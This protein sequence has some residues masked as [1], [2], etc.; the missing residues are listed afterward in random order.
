MLPPVDSALMPSLAAPSSASWSKKWT[1]VH[2]G[3][4]FLPLLQPPA[5]S[6]LLAG[7]L[8]APAIE[9]NL[10]AG[11]A[12]HSHSHVLLRVNVGMYAFGLVWPK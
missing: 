11:V 8:G 3:V 6:A 2:L 4:V 10:C 5:A 9:P 12:C 1:A 7:W